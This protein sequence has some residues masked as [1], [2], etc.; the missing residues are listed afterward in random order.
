MLIP[1]SEHIVAKI[2]ASHVWTCFTTMIIFQHDD[3]G[4]DDD[5]DDDDGADVERTHPEM[6]TQSNENW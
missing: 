4:D 6:A 3:D 1:H 5:D 2:L